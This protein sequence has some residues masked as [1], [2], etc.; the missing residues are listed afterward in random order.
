MMNPSIR[1]KEKAN[2]SVRFPRR[3]F[4]DPRP[5]SAAFQPAVRRDQPGRAAPGL[6]RT[7]ARAFN[8]Y[9]SV[10]HGRS[11]RRRM[12]VRRGFRK[13]PRIISMPSPGAGRSLSTTSSPMASAMAS[14]ANRI[15]VDDRW[16]IVRV[17]SRLAVTRMRG[18]TTCPASSAMHLSPP[19]GGPAR[20]PL[21]PARLRHDAV[22]CTA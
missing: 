13:P 1:A 12:I 8:I 17:H 2:S 11:R 21:M 18:W 16:A 3:P 7:R 22:A 6:A 19:P 10:C 4:G 9:C 14:Y 15:D 5:R 20:R